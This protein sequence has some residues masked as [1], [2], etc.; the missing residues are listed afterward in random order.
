MGQV[1][2]SKGKAPPRGGAELNLYFYFYFV[3]FGEMVGQGFRRALAFGMNRFQSSIG[4]AGVDSVL[5]RKEFRFG[6]AGG[7]ADTK[8]HVRRC[9]IKDVV[10]NFAHRCRGP[11][12]FGCLEL[13]SSISGVPVIRPWHHTSTQGSARTP[14][15]RIRFRNL[16]K[17]N[18]KL[19]AWM[20]SSVIFSLFH[21]SARN[22]STTEGDK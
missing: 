13:R 17:I 14:I 8:A 3:G 11:S 9:V 7:R 15:P 22:H 16:S 18:G 19:D 5:P 12:S 1:R 2:R 21:K 20:Q 6:G 10:G 4:Y